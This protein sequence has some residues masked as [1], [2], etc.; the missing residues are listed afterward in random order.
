MEAGERLITSG[1]DTHLVMWDVRPHDVTGSKV[2]KVLDLM[3]ITT[4]KNS[5]VGDKSAITP[6]G[7]RIGTPAMTTRGMREPEMARICAFLLKAVEIAK[8]IQDTAGRK[9]NE[10]NAA[11]EQDAEILAIREEVHAFASQYPMPGL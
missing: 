11:V 3:H 8:R 7:V 6:G 10:F 4:N 2:D 9:L 1:T 5:V